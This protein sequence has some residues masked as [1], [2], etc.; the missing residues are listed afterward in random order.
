ML[1]GTK[2]RKARHALVCGK[3]PNGTGTGYK[4][5]KQET[6]PSSPE[7]N[8]VGRLCE[9]IPLAFEHAQIRHSGH[10]RLILRRLASPERL[11]SSDIE[12]Y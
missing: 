9:A 11:V 7:Q 8:K 3:A 4:Q 2:A 5:T 6:S 1:H 10:G 12:R